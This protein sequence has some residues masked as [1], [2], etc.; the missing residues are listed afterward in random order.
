MYQVQIHNF[1]G[2][3]F[4]SEKLGWKMWI[5]GGHLGNNYVTSVAARHWGGE[6]G[7]LD[8]MYH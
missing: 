8:R 5:L 1:K 6:G 7:G 4:N 2:K 3:E